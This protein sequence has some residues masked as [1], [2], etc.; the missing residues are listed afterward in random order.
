M[1]WQVSW[2]MM[3]LTAVA[4]ADVRPDPL[5]GGPGSLVLAAVLISA[6]FAVWGIR[7]LRKQKK[8]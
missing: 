7:K 1:K 8:D 2:M 4:L 6:G 3:G 5:D